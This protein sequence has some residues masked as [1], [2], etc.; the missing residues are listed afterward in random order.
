MIIEDDSGL[1]R[2]I[3]FALEQEG[4]ETI[5]ARTLR[6][7]YRLFGQETPEAVILDLNLPDGDG[8]EFC[9]RIR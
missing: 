1:N 5:S 3:S 6:E 2:G 4:Y 8:M 9:R 7:G